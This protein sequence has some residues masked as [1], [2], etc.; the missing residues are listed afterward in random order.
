MSSSKIIGT[1]LN[2]CELYSQI[3]TRLSRFNLLLGFVKNAFTW[4]KPASAM[5]EVRN[6]TRKRSAAAM[7]IGVL[8]SIIDISPLFTEIFYF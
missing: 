8:S 4:Q 6:D 2:I 5:Y 7:T 3:T 1:R